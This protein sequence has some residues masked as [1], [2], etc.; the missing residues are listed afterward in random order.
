M[1]SGAQK[2]NHLDS[3]KKLNYDLR[4]NAT[5]LQRSAGFVMFREMIAVYSDNRAKP[6]N[7][8]CDQSAVSE[9]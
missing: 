1:I 9:C 4:E 2:H 8:V 6:V 5:T 3:I 7:I